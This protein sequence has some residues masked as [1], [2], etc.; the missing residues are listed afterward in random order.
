MAAKPRIINNNKKPP[1]IAKN[2]NK[3]P[4]PLDKEYEAAWQLEY[5]K[6]SSD[7]K[8]R[9]ERAKRDELDG[10]YRQD[11]IVDDFVKRVVAVV[12]TPVAAK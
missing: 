1:Q 8:E 7:D 3:T 9:V 12:E 5:E 4:P 2:A 11:R 6:L 10:S